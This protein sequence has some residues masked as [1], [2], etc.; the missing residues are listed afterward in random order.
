MG[1]VRHPQL[2]IEHDSGEL[3]V[4]EQLQQSRQLHLRGWRLQVLN[5]WSASLQCL[6][7]KECY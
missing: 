6:G 1:Q 7:V 5:F 2:P 4:E 3:G